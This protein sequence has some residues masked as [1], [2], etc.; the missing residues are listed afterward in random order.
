MR[1]MDLAEVGLR[2]DYFHEATDDYLRRLGVDRA[3]LPTRSAWQ[4]TSEA[5]FAR[6]VADRETLLLVWERDGLVVGFSSADRIVFGVE[7]FMH[8]HLLHAS[9]RGRGLGTNFVRRSARLYFELLGL[10][11]LYCEP[12]AL[13]IAPNRT[14]QAAGFRYLFT[15]E[16]APTPINYLQ[17]MTRW[18]LE[19]DLVDPAPEG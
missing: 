19:R 4:A 7:A 6:P 18:V 9:D 16:T 3:L 13:N 11:R 17:L 12:N 2:I 8:L 5:D 14:L 10:D 15:H 1:L